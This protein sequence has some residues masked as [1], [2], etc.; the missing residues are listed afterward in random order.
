MKIGSWVVGIAV[1]LAASVHA[2]ESSWV[3]KRDAS[4]LAV[5]G[6]CEART[7]HWEGGSIY[8]LSDVAVEQVLAGEPRRG[9][10]V[11]RQRGG[12]VGGIGQK[13]SHVPL[14]EPGERYLLFLSP[15]ASGELAPLGGG[16]Q[17]IVETLDGTLSAAGVPLAELLESLGVSR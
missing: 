8:S 9:T 3:A 11:V 6:R 5:V 13:V 16:V 10:V 12:T 17:R 1:S 14:L 4:T 15:D 2:V 7:S